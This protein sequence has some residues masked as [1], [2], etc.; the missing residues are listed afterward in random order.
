M[1]IF[2]TRL[3]KSFTSWK[4]DKANQLAAATAYYTVFSLAP[5]LIIIISVA[6]FFFTSSDVQATILTG[7]QGLLGNQGSEAVAS[8]LIA[9]EHTPSSTLATVVGCIALVLGATGLVLSLRDA[10]NTIWQIELHPEK[11]NIG[12]IIVRRIFSLLFILLIGFLFLASLLAS[13]LLSIFNHFIASI[14]FF[15]AILL[16][17][18]NFLLSFAIIFALFALLLKFL[19]DLDIPWREIWQPAVLTTALFI[20]GKAAFAWY[21]GQKNFVSAY[22]IAGSLI[23]LLLW[24]NYSAQIFFFGVEYCKEYA[25]E[26]ELRLEPKPYARFVHPANPAIHP[27]FPFLDA[28]L[29]AGL[30][31]LEIKGFK[32]WRSFKKKLD[33]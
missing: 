3:K 21:F 24:I 11:N 9:A 28:L 19:P 25:R 23:A 17:L 12:R 8:M 29:S 4:K 22:G 7:S 30:L 26:R 2:T 1:K 20:I 32:K 31:F 16:T 6:R 13:T 18:S 14:F 33:H 15:P 10:V 5:L 27:A